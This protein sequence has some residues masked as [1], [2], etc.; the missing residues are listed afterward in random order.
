MVV[1]TE[2]WREVVGRKWINISILYII[3]EIYK[4]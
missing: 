2:S 3:Y 1:P 4:E